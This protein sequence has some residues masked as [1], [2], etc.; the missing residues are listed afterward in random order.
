MKK[1]GKSTQEIRYYI[2]SL[3]VE[4]TC[5]KRA[6]RGHWG[7]ESFNWHLD[8]TFGEDANHTLHQTATRYL[9][10]IRKMAIPMLKELPFNLKY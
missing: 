10:I 4:A 7:I 8:V 3:H 1:R 9:N 6:V 5:F 2:S